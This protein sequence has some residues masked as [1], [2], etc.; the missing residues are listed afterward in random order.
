VRQ[1]RTALAQ[2]IEGAAPSPKAWEGVLARMTGPEPRPSRLRAWST[3]LV[4]RLRIGSAMAGATL[5]IVLALNVEI[6]PVRTSDA[7]PGVV[8]P[9]TAARPL[10]LADGFAQAAA[11]APYAGTTDVRSAGDEGEERV[12]IAVGNHEPEQLPLHRPALEAAAPVAEDEPSAT[13]ATESSQEWQPLTLRLVPAD[14]AVMRASS[15]EPPAEEAPSGEPAPQSR[16]LP[17]G[18]PS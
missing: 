8:G 4:A 6:V 3:L 11:T 16:P 17:S 18:A 7:S 12:T 15:N 13:V 9:A 2:R 5:A 1:L 10:T 14:A